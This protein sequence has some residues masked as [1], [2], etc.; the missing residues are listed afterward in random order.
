MIPPALLKLI[1]LQSRGF[2]RRTLAS[3]RSPRRAAFLLIG[4]AVVVL[5]L[6]PAVFTS[7][8]FGH[9]PAAGRLPAYRFREI[10][11]LALLGMCLLTILSSAGDKAI[12]F[13]AGEV[14]M[15]FP[16]P[17]TRRQLLAYKLLKSALAALLTSV[18]VSIGL[19]PYAQSWVTCYVGVFLTLL[20]VQFFSTAGV[21]LGQAIGQRAYTATRA[22]MLGLALI[23]ALLLARHW[24]GG[25]RGAE[26]IDAFRESD[27][28]RAILRPFEPFADA[29]TARPGGE[30]L[31]GAAE[32]AAIDTG[33]L[34]IVVLLDAN[35]LEAALAASQRRYAQIQRIRSGAL[36]NA[37]LKGD[38]AWRLPRPW[39]LGGAGPIV[40]RQATN[41]AR[42]AK[43]LMI[44]LL[45]VALAIGPLFA[46]ALDA[47]EVTK[48]LLAVMAWLTVLLSGL[49][50]FDFRGDLDHFDQLKSLPL[51]PGMIALGQLVVPTAILSL[52]HVLLLL[53]VAAATATAGADRKILFT[54]AALALPF[55]AL[56]MSTENLIFLLFPSRPAA[57]SPGD[58]QV[59][60]RQAAQLVL[61][62][63]AVIAGCAV[64]FSV[65]LPLFVLTGGSFVV[66]T[67]VAGSMLLG[68]TAALLPAVAWA[69]NRFDPSVDTPA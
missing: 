46:S 64:A 48:P 47:T 27:A 7:A 29:M 66:V 6:A 63:V 34:A 35:Y 15:L 26:A 11:P 40:W 61:K 56:L 14:D 38:V 31:A 41:A 49:L 20:F 53:G 67:V 1:A 45:V 16:G 58:F 52:A 10:A 50:K 4:V 65:A 54:A 18:I 59:L 17:F 69:Y 13:T 28:G 22:A 36:L 5:W 57:A 2:Y 21:M 39:W 3:A 68:E 32:A 55:N 12:A 60:G 30:F 8:A 24:V 43:G 42:S 62:S 25:M 23:V 44:V 51:R 37:N 9:S 19:L 33:L